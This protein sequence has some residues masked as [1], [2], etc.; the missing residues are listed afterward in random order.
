MTTPPQAALVRC[1]TRERFEQFRGPKL[2]GMGYGPC[3]VCGAEVVMS[4]S[5]VA[6]CA[7]HVVAPVCQPCWEEH[8]TLLDPALGR[9]PG[10]EEDRRNIEIA[11][12]FSEN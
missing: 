1:C 3:K 5:T 9:A 11:R 8:F 12:K 6:L 7:T 4:P 10:Y 2:T